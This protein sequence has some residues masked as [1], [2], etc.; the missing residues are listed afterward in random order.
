[1]IL[2]RELTELKHQHKDIAG[3]REFFIKCDSRR[4]DISQECISETDTSSL[5]CQDGLFYWLWKARSR[6]G[7]T[8]F[9][10]KEKRAFLFWMPS[11]FFF[12]E[13]KSIPS[14]FNLWTYVLTFSVWQHQTHYH[15]RAQNIAY[16]S[17]FKSHCFW[18][19]WTIHKHRAGWVWI[20]PWHPWWVQCQGRYC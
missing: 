4:H 19:C 14:F 15:A 1:M 12:F 17:I 8:F 6:L 13:K 5:I 20:I 3:W 9:D 7:G 10:T 16:Q 11:H 2:R 18:W